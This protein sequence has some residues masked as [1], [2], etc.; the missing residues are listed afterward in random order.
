MVNIG[1]VD[2]EVN[3]EVDNNSVKE[4]EETVPAVPCNLPANRV[5]LGPYVWFEKT[6][7]RVSQ[8]KKD[9]NPL[10]KVFKAVVPEIEN[11]VEDVSLLTVK[12]DENEKQTTVDEGKKKENE[13]ENCKMSDVK[14]APEEVN[15][16]EKEDKPAFIEETNEVEP[17]ESTNAKPST[18]SRTTGP[19]SK[20]NAPLNFD[21]N[22]LNTIRIASVIPKR[23]KVLRKKLKGWNRKQVL[24]KKISRLLR[25]SSYPVTP[26]TRCQVKIELSSQVTP[27]YPNS[28]KKRARS[29]WSTRQEL[30]SV[31]SSPAKTAFI[32]VID[33]TEDSS[34]SDEEPKKTSA[35][36]TAAKRNVPV[37]KVETV[38]KR[39]KKKKKKS[40]VITKF[41]LDDVEM[42]HEGNGHASGIHAR[43]TRKARKKKSPP[44][45]VVRSTKSS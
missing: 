8:I 24:L 5:S 42:L 25:F 33:L 36:F 44:A 4:K 39:T 20:M 22:N 16:V 32:P 6:L 37:K 35:R 43:H 11:V 9:P 31:T 13:S 28:P 45:K 10:M 1:I 41:G 40:R 21:S 12:K 29:S 38:V 2:K 27:K 19:K 23:P 30:E 18:P 3:G 17:E 34:F 26:L 7:P 14:S 15:K